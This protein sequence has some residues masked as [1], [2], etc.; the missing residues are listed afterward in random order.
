M[1]MHGIECEIGT[2][3]RYVLGRVTVFKTN[4]PTNYKEESQQDQDECQSKNSA[5]L[6]IMWLCNCNIYVTT[7]KSILGRA[8]YGFIIWRGTDPYLYLL[9]LVDNYL[10]EAIVISAN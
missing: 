7:M 2:G 10:F 5:Q 8:P 9:T 3:N 6:R 1:D 4:L